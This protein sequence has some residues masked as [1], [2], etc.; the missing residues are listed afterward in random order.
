MFEALKAKIA[1]H[2]ESKPKLLSWADTKIELDMTS[3]SD[4]EQTEEAMLQAAMLSAAELDFEDEFNEA[5]SFQPEDSSSA[6][7]FTT[8]CGNADP[9][10][11]AGN[12]IADQPPLDKIEFT[13]L[14]T[15]WFE[16][17]D[18]RGRE[19][20]LRRVKRLAEGKRSYALCKR[21]HNTQ[22]PIYEAKLGGQ[23]ILWTKLKR[24]DILSILFGLDCHC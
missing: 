3:S 8:H 10:N 17:A 13:P 24:G 22:T 18:K 1:A 20:L 15:K 5:M 2:T 9:N 21:L 12:Q 16:R 19:M 14:T 11:A 23:R 7:K 4:A 6:S